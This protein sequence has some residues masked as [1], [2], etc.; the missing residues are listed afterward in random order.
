MP[1]SPVAALLSVLSAAVSAVT[2]AQ[3]PEPTAPA[4][5]SFWDTWPFGPGY[6]EP[7]LAMAAKALFLLLILGGVVLFLRLLHGPKGLF[8]DKSW[9]EDN[10]R[11]AREE[12]AELDRRLAAGEISETDHRLHRKRLLKWLPP[13]SRN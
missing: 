8:R 9:D 2:G 4:V 13:D 10:E 6:G 3:A 11:E 12:L 1:P 7:L 5:P